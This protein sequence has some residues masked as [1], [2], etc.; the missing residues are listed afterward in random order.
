MGKVLDAAAIA[1]FRRDGLYAPVQVASGE[2]ARRLRAQLEAGETDHGGPFKGAVR[3]KSHL[4][5][6][7][8]SDFIRK[9]SVLDPVEDILGPNIMVWS[10]DWWVKEA[11]SPSYV[12]W[13]QD[14]QY[15]GLDSSKLITLWVALSP[16][17][18]ASGCMRYLLGSHLGPDLP[19]RETYHDD[20]MLTRGQ[21]ITEGID[22]AKAVNVE[23]DPGEGSIFAFRIAHASHPNR[24]ADRRI[25][26][27]IRFIPPDARQIR[28]DHD[29]AALVRGVDT[30]G[31]FEL[32]PEP[33][34][35]FDPLAVEFHRWSEEERRKILYHGTDWE[36]HRT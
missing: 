6:K 13:H 7:W 18:V 23:L 21:E 11:N 29:S 34:Y 27:A 36:T 26:L 9:K 25:G 24:S 30:H 12:S 31:H 16:S 2:E 17:N 5:F 15:W 10:T 19:H 4:L 14:S 3:Y 8:L 35:D 32:E 22:E 20:N 28:S 33:E 1:Q